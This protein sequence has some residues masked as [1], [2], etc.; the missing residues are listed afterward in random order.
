MEWG[1]LTLPFLRNLEIGGSYEQG[2]LESLPEKWLLP[3]TLSFLGIHGF[4]N[5]KS[6]YNKG[7]QDLTSLGT[8]V[9]SECEK[10]KYFPKQG[11]PSSLSCL[12]IRD[13]PL[14]KKRCQRDKGKEWPKISHIPSI[15]L[16][17]DES[18]NEESISFYEVILS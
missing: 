17:E 4:P 16:E 18:S 3:S 13:C 9:I 14:L 1:L 6:L 15:V 5:L 10:L 11:L 8:L 2:R 7:L 12:K